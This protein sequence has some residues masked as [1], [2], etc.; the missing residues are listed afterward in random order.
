V[1]EEPVGSAGDREDRTREGVP[2]DS[3]TGVEAV[4]VIRGDGIDVVDSLVIVI[5]GDDEVDVIRAPVIIIDSD[6]EVLVTTRRRPVVDDGVDSS[7]DESFRDLDYEPSSSRDVSTE[8]ES[9]ETDGGRDE[10]G[11]ECDTTADDEG[12]VVVTSSTRKRRIQSA[13]RDWDIDSSDDTYQRSRSRSNKRRRPPQ[14]RAQVVDSGIVMPSSS[15]SKVSTPGSHDD[16]FEH[17]SSLPNVGWMIA[18]S[19]PEGEGRLREPGRAVYRATDDEG[20]GGE[21]EVPPPSLVISRYRQWPALEVLK[22]Q[23]ET[24]CRVCLACVLDGDFGG[25]VH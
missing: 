5:P 6:D 4:D 12:V 13:F 7:G 15:Q 20:E 19:R 1:Y 3:R 2:I 18:P 17:R 9:S 24:W 25:E 8:G 23:L 22:V 10:G 11:K 14:K 16:G 21:S